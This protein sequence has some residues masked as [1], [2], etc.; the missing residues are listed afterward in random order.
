MIR[1]WSFFGSPWF[2]T[3]CCLVSIAGCTALAFTQDDNAFYIAAL[4]FWAVFG[5]C[6]AFFI[7][8]E[9]RMS[10]DTTTQAINGWNEQEDLTMDLTHLLAESLGKLSTWDREASD[11]IAE[12]T[13]TII[14]LRFQNFKER[15]H[16]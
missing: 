15:N 9:L 3:S 1:L 10:N 12:R 16:P 7:L 11:D 14:R 13:N 8:R 5:Q 2:Y 6:L 4:C